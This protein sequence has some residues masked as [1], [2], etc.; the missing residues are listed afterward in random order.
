MRLFYRIQKDENKN[1][2]QQVVNLEAQFK[3]P[4]L[5]KIEN[6]LSDFTIGK[7][8]KKELINE[9]KKLADLKETIKIDEKLFE[10]G[11]TIFVWQL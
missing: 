9:D 10:T 1:K 2:E 3:S 6:K 7:S 4:V 8:I 5:D 11:K